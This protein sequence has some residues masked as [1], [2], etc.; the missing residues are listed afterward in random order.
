[1]R[2]VGRKLLTRA[3]RR[4]GKKVRVESDWRSYYSSSPALLAEVERRGP[5]RFRRRII[6]FARGKAPLMY[7]EELAQYVLGVLEQPDRWYNT[8]IRSRIF[9]RHLQK[10]AADIAAARDALLRL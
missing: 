6:A 8:N 9:G 1:M 10:H 2:Y 3:A 4:R 5:E 7:L